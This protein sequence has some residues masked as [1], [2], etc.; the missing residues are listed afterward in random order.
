MTSSTKRR[1]SA[2]VRTTPKRMVR[3]TA[4]PKPRRRFSRRGGGRPQEV[5]SCRSLLIAHARA[6]VGWVMSRS[7]SAL[8][9]L[10]KEALPLD[11]EGE[12][13][14]EATLGCGKLQSTR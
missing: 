1:R 7:G 5:T 14:G 6:L 9:A 11:P 3:H 12:C 8:L 13:E 4:D 2:V 10:F